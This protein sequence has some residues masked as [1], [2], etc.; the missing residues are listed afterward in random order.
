[1]KFNTKCGLISLIFIAKLCIPF[2][3][4]CDVG[5]CARYKINIIFDDS[6]SII[7]YTQLGSYDT[8]L[9]YLS[10]GEILG[11]MK[12][13]AISDSITLFKRIQTLNY[14]EGNKHYGFKYSAVANEDRVVIDV[15]KISNIQKLAVSRCEHG[16]FGENDQYNIH[17]T[18]Q[19]IDGLSQEEIDLLQTKPYSIITIGTP[20]LYD[21]DVCLNYNK[22]IDKQQ[23]QKLC[24]LHLTNE[25]N[26][27]HREFEQL[28]TKHYSK[29]V[30]KLRSMNII[31]IHLYS[32]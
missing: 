6:D 7:C 2:Y 25:K 8:N 12:E 26:L 11:R 3:S 17:F 31:I 30:Q 21:V 32:D 15:S 29:T 9:K 10:E 23:L 20:G 5:S 27:P 22:N 16:N 4:Y 14:P 1:M 19:I 13:R 18:S 24:N 28:Q